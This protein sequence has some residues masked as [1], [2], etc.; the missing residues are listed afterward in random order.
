M[1]LPWWHISREK[2][3]PVVGEAWL[4][5]SIEKQEAQPLDAYDVVSDLTAAGTGIPMDKQDPTD[6]AF[7]TITAEVTTHTI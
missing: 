7:E 2:S 4:L 3:I 6:E 5:D 1:F